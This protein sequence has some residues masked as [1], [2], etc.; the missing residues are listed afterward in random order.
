MMKRARYLL[1]C[2]V[3]LIFAGMGW[4][5][6]TSQDVQ[7]QLNQKRQTSIT[8]AIAKVSPAVV[9]VNVTQI[10]RYRAHPFFNDPL[11]NMF[12]GDTYQQKVQSL[13]SGFIVSEDGYVLTNAHVVEGA[14]E[15][16]ITTPGGEQHDGELIGIDNVSD[17]ALVKIEGNDFPSVTFGNSD[18]I[19]IGEWV[20]ALGN[21]F[22]LFDVS[23][24]PTATAG[25]ISG[26]H[27]D[28]GEQR[29]GQRYQNMIQTDASINT[30]NSGG[31]LVNANG[32]VIG[33]STFIFT[34]G[35]YNQGSIGIGFAI[36]INRAK[37]IMADLK[38]QGQIDWSFD[39]GLKIQEVDRHISSALNLPVNDGIIVTG[40]ERG[41][42]ADKA[43]VK[44]GDII[45]EAAGEPIRSERDIFDAIQN[46]YLHAGDILNLK[47][48]RDGDAKTIKLKLESVR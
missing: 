33:I 8:D 1:L 39:T 27:M 37:Q 40:V 41:S 38:E 17:L 31:P 45:T 4:S 12:F 5:Q 13:G 15:I 26:L 2:S 21:P 23:Y 22:G 3:L 48:W 24:Q 47:V 20:V 36:P 46:N 32:E 30:G 14:A 28:F 9:G 29:K 10:R 43:G 34:G 25:I 18:D 19:V 11:L 7:N 6:T 42:P 35:G 16:V 44:V